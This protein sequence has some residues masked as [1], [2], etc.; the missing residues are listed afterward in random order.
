MHAYAAND[1]SETVVAEVTERWL[2]RRSETPAWICP[3]FSFL[4]QNLYQCVDGAGLAA[5]VHDD[6]PVAASRRPD[7]RGRTCVV[8]AIIVILRA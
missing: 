6:M 4:I 5:E 8:A 1:F 3:G 2:E 7:D